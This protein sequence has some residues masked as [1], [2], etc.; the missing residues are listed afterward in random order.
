LFVAFYKNNVNPTLSS[1]PVDAHT[2]ALAAVAHAL[3]DKAVVLEHDEESRALATELGGSG[4]QNPS[5]ALIDWAPLSK[6]EFSLRVRFFDDSKPHTLESLVSWATGCIDGKECHFIT[7]VPRSHV[8][9]ELSQA[10]YESF[11]HDIEYDVVV[12]FAD[13]TSMSRMKDLLER[14]NIAAGEVKTLRFAVVDI[15]E[16]PAAKQ[17]F[18]LSFVRVGPAIW[19]FPAGAAKSKPIFSFLSIPGDKPEELLA[20]WAALK[21]THKFN[22]VHPGGS[23]R[24][25]IPDE[26]NHTS[27]YWRR[28]LSVLANWLGAYW[29]QF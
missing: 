11:V 27:V 16:V 4:R 3:G 21:A 8:V 5:F 24:K 13:K 20:D 18:D 12:A 26:T 9:V 7:T 29:V 2:A 14:V 22:T 10:N 25:V 23:D 17:F 19:M 15:D 6:H 28:V 1:A